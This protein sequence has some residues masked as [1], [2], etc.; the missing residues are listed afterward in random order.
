MFDALKNLGGLGNLGELMRKAGKMKEQFDT[1]RAELAKKTVSADAGA[2]I[3]EAT[4]N[5]QL[6]LV[7]MKIDP[8]RIN[9]SDNEML[10]DLIVAAVRAAQS[11]AQ[12]MMQ[13]ALRKVAEDSDLPIPPGMMP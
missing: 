11:K 13:E 2:G 6:E 5:G 9:P 3:V 4:V 10:E 1:M 12:A 7:R 8:T